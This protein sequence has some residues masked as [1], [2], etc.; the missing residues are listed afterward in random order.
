[1]AEYLLL[2][3]MSFDDKSFHWG[4]TD[5]ALALQHQT[6]NP[7]TPYS[8][9]TDRIGKRTDSFV[10]HMLRHDLYTAF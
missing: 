8:D 6:H 10:V 2:Y 1:M 5:V 4:L 9:T 7:V 3:G